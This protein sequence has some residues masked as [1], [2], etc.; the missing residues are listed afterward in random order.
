MA[1]PVKHRGKWR[2]RWF[3]SSGRR[4]SEVFENRRDAEFALR[5]HEVDADEIRR[6]LRPAPVGVHQFS[7]L[8]ERWLTHRSSQKRSEKDDRSIIRR[9]LVP[10]FGELRISEVTPIRIENLRTGLTQS[11]KTVHNILTL[12]VS[13]LN[14]AVE[15]GWLLESQ[16]PRVRKPRVQIGDRDFCYLRTK[17]EV[18]RFLVAA[19]DEGSDV[20]A[21]FATAIFTGMRAGELA[22][23]L[24]ENV[25]LDRRL[26]TVAHSYAG[27]TKAGY[28]RH[29]PVLAPI[30]PLLRSWR[31]Q[32]PGQF[33]FPSRTGTM[34]VPSGRIF[35]D[36]FQRVLRSAGLEQPRSPGRRR[37]L[38]FHGLRHTFASHWMMAGGDLFT[39]QRIGGWKTPMMVQRYAHLSPDAFAKDYDLL[40]AELPTTGGSPVIELGRGGA[41]HG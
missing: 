1:T 37:V 41:R 13:M 2:I 7:E 29:V 4:K 16:R 34:L 40:G 15:L 39:L 32:C 14:Y 21:I 30:L 38:T 26:I 24:W 11:P 27:P 36:V 33:V 31:L 8:V 12:L 6:G 28:I 23:L 18:R 25:D 22:G 3:D 19:L 5:R 10:A 9:H 17:D 35:Q 20:H